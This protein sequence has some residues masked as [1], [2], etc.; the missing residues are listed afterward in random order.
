MTAHNVKFIK[1]QNHEGRTKL[2]SAAKTRE[3]VL[4]RK[5]EVLKVEQ[6]YLNV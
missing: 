1:E 5:L 3:V 6:D 4:E 2:I